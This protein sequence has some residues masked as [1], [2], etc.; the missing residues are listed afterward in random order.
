MMK[1]NG[2]WHYI[3]INNTTFFCWVCK[4]QLKT[5]ETRSRREKGKKIRLKIGKS[6]YK[7]LVCFVFKI[8]QVELYLSFLQ[9]E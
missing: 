1:S 2:F 4:I 8:L 6:F 9:L 3:S 5:T 7:K